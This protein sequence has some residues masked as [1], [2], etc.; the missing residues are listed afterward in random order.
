M[1]R[2]PSKEDAVIIVGAGIFGLS[3]AVHLSRRGYKNVT[4]YDK[5]PYHESLY[6]YFKGADGA[7]ADMNKIIRSAY[8]AQ[9]EYQGLT[10]EALEGW[11]A[12]NKELASGKTVPPGLTT[13]DRVFVNN[14][15]LSLSD[16][17]SLPQ[18]EQ[19]TVDNMEAAGHRNTQLIT[20]D[21]QHQK[22]AAEKG[23][24][25]G[26]DP[27]RRLQRGLNAAG[28]LDTTG[29]M[30]VAD[31][32]CRFAL[33]KAVSQGVKFVLD[34]QA[35]ALVSLI[36]EGKKVIGIKT[37]DGRA[38]HAK[39]TILACGGWTPSLLPALDGL[40]ETTAGSV[41]LLKIP[42]E[43]P[44]FT[45]FAP[46]N[47]PTFT[48]KVRDGVEGGLYG[49]PRD[50][51]G[52]L[53]IGYRGTKYTNPVTQADGKERSVPVT[54]W[55]T[56]SAPGDP[57]EAT[58]ER[59]TTI[60]QQALKVLRSFLAENL[61]ELGAEGIDISFTRV[62]WYT[63]S[64]DNHFV[65]GQVPETEESLM[66]ATGGSGHAF[67]Y[68]PNIGNWVVDAVEKKGQDQIPPKLWKWR[69]IGKQEKPYNVL[70]EG[71]KGPTALGNVPLAAEIEI[72]GDVKSRL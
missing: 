19:D 64:Y 51:D 57:N 62:C 39:L 5:Q 25:F 26:M 41:V 36:Y 11:T 1:A 35:G 71:S 61:P 69:Q 31:K 66:V 58:N 18:F 46:E 55:S 30:A 42:R 2:S 49:F 40:C 72:A 52:W 20:I 45:R 4:V 10:I 63:D 6:S 7:S 24:S 50:E 9:T 33:H 47:F 60:P 15:N 44:L 68:L 53:K 59:L 70:M 43:S 37:R 12:W 23:W 27:F 21:E 56:A 3:T 14:G 48:Y 17:A 54:R 65:I 8:G 22:F 13:D 29:G 38:H 32:A 28:V 16:S 67:K 34:P